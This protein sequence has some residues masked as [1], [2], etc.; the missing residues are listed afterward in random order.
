MADADQFKTLYAEERA[1]QTP[2]ITT[3]Y[4]YT[5]LTSNTDWIDAVTRTGQFGSYNLSIAGSTEKNRSISG[6]AILLMKV[7]S[8]MRNWRSYWFL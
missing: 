7:L 8:G 3:P 2:P 1:N 4:D 6:W 5:G